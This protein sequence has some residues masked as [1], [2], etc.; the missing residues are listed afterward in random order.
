MR[1][2][3]DVNEE[4]SQHIADLRR[5]MALRGHSPEEVDAATEAELQRMG[6]LAAA[7]RER[8]RDAADLA[9]GKRLFAGLWRDLVHAARLL[10]SKRAYSS[11]VVL[12]LAVGIGGCAAVFSLFN[13]LLLRPLAF[14]DPERLVLVW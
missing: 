3:K 11:V 1:E 14:P 13:S 4:A 12:T 10:A 9:Q 8:P 2:W 7:V 6:A 5:M